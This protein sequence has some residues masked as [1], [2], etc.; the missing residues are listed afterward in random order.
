MSLIGAKRIVF[1]CSFGGENGWGHVIR[2]SALAAEFRRH[3]WETTLW[4]EGDLALLP[5]D[6]ASAF[7]GYSR[8][9]EEAASILVVD[10]MYTE[11]SVLEAFVGG[12]KARNVGGVAAGIDDMQR[13][14]M[15]GFDLV[16]NTEIGL[17]EAAYAAGSVLL[18]ERYALLRAGFRDADFELDFEL[19][20]GLVPVFVM[21]GGTDPFSFLPRVLEGMARY[22]VAEFAP[23][24]VAGSAT[25]AEGRL[26]AFR[27]SRVLRSVG[28]AE[29]GA[30]M[31]ICRFGIVACGSSLYE[32]AAMELP[33]VGLSLVDNQTASARKVDTYWGMP[34][35]HCEGLASRELEMATALDVMF[36][37][38]RGPYSEVD[39]LG[40]ERVRKALEVLLV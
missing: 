22:K 30:W 33:F 36:A 34:V 14:S 29:L 15:R 2:C 12:W 40:A 28:A 21:M 20:S 9:G 5:S 31:R 32:C 17:R 25:D 6:V 4:S 23:V 38:R 24:V 18:G 13:R 11:Q 7:I 10:E 8:R 1:K 19:E 26:A 16:L 3:G 27:Q 39:L 37:K 35:L